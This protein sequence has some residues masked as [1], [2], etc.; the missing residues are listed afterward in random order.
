MKI[1][2]VDERI[3]LDYLSSIGN[4]IPAHEPDGNI[5]PDFAFDNKIG[6]EV[7]RLNQNYLEGA[8]VEGIEQVSIRIHQTLEKCFDSLDTQYNGKTY[9]VAINYKRPITINPKIIK[10]EITTTL[11]RFLEK[12]KLFPAT[13]K[14]NSNIS[15]QFIEATKKYNKLFKLG[16]TLDYNSGGWLTQLFV[17]NVSF[18]VVEKTEKTKP[19]KSRYNEWWLLLVDR[20][21]LDMPKED[22]DEI[23]FSSLS[24][25]GFNK[26]IIIEPKSLKELFSY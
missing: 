6:I 1:Q 24:K 16:I 11:Q 5:P 17:E 3:A 20:I 13:F 10:R 14:V 15:L 23:D 26:V 7:R 19:Y 22:Y 18:C 25:G 8:D 9:F 2:N 12:P 21:G 4:G